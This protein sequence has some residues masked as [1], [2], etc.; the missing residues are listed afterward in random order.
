MPAEVKAG[1]NEQREQ[2]ASFLDLEVLQ[3]LRLTL[4]TQG[5]TFIAAGDSSTQS[6]CVFPPGWVHS[7]P[8]G[9]MTAAKLHG[10]LLAKQI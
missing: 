9:T 3:H 5:L 6:L 8:G 7:P 2:R 1:S 10:E 4:G